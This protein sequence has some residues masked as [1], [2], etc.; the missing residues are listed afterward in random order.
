MKRGKSI[1]FIA[2]IICLSLS[3]LLA[4]CSPRDEVKPITTDDME[5]GKYEVKVEDKGEYTVFI[6]QCRSD[7]GFIFYLGTAMNANNYK[8]ILTDI[9]S[10]GINVMV[11]H[12]AFAELKYS[13]T[14]KI[15]EEIYNEYGIKKYFIG[16][17]SQGG[18][19]AI[20]YAYENGEKV[21]GLILYSPFASGN[22]SLKESNLPVIYFEAENDKVLNQ[23]QKDVTRNCLA[24]DIEYIFIEG[25]NHMCYG[26]AKFID[27]E[28]ERDLKE[29]QREISEK[30]S[31]YILNV[32]KTE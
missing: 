17:H 5:L 31:A 10:S 12:N 8:N 28:L 27:G 3:L 9:A 20:R 7:Y 4:G 15:T 6:P 32:L 1:M 22:Y 11:V 25:G 13:E 16:G 14:D 2:V 26:D 18:G 29:V 21:Q 24:E 30:T 23:E 19:A